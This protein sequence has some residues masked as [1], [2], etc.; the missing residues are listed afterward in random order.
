MKNRLYFMSRNYKNY[1]IN[2]GTNFRDRLLYALNLTH[3]CISC[4]VYMITFLAS[5]MADVF[6]DYKRVYDSP[7]FRYASTIH[8]RDNI[9]MMITIII[10]IIIL[11]KGC[12]GYGM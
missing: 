4:T 7:C 3:P 11:S 6:R 12:D 5:K 1:I 10:T 2:D 8:W 9:K